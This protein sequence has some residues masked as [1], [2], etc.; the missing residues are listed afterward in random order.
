MRWFRRKRLEP[1]RDEWRVWLRSGMV[2]YGLLADGEREQLELLTSLLLVDKRWEAAQGFELTEEMRVTI[3]AQAALL[4]LGLDY[5]HYR[6]VTSIIVHPTTLVLTGP[7]AGPARGVLTDHPL[8]IIGQAHHRG[9]VIVAWDA[10]RHAARHPERG[11]NVVYHEFAHQ[12]DMLDGV[13]DGTPP[14]DRDAFTRWVDVFTEEYTK[15]RAGTAGHLVS[16]YGGVN[17]GEFFAVVTEVFFDRPIQMRTEKPALYEV[18]A[19]FYR[20]DPAAREQR[21]GR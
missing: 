9:P 18:L 14:L 10:A 12:L 8:S 11:H 3:A 6:N 19:G 7:R 17:P 16:S 15:L 20:Q 2:H 1:F 4:V 21:A 13:V 5:G